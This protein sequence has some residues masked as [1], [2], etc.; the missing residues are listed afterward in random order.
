MYAQITHVNIPIKDL[1]ILAQI[2]NET[3]QTGYNGYLPQI[4]FGLF[5]F[6]LLSCL[7]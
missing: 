7:S 5:K 6:D 3:L 4:C 2:R 1:S